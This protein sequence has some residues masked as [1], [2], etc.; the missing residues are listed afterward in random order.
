MNQFIKN[1]H[2]LYFSWTTLIILILLGGWIPRSHGAELSH[3][4]YEL[5]P[6]IPPQGHTQ[7]CFA[8]SAFYS[9]QYFRN[10]LA[11]LGAPRPKPVSVSQIVTSLW[12]PRYLDQPGW[13]YAALHNLRK[14]PLRVGKEPPIEA[15]F[16]FERNHSQFLESEMLEGYSR[17][18]QTLL[19]DV[20]PFTELAQIST[21]V[22]EALSEIPLERRSTESLLNRILPYEQVPPP[23]YNVFVFEPTDELFALRRLTNA[24]ITQETWVMEEI[25]RLLSPDP[26]SGISYPLE[27]SYCPSPRGEDCDFHSVSVIGIRPHELQVW[28]DWNIRLPFGF[29]QVP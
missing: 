28:T 15:L 7:T 12:G 29:R 8:L 13:T 11:P 23:T 1:G 18:W 22:Q 4:Q 25:E 6:E 26:H 5:S 19:R 24:R 14:T 2:L 10:L 17:D 16:D 9:L 27:F 21:R 3:I 20:M